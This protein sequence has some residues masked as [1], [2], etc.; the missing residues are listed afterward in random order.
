M[1]KG[2]KAS[3]EHFTVID[4]NEAGVDLVLKHTA[5]PLPAANQYS[6]SIISIRKQLKEVCIQ[7]V[8][9]LLKGTKP[10][11]VKFFMFRFCSG[12]VIESEFR[13]WNT[14]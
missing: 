3:I 10:K 14:D 9:R 1:R 11:T 13:E 7:N 12:A 5:V 8:R 6:A 4:G 2:L